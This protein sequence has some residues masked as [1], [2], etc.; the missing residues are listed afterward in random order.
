[1]TSFARWDCC[2]KDIVFIVTGKPKTSYYGFDDMVADRITH[3]ST[4]IRTF[5]SPKLVPGK[6]DKALRLSGRLQK[7]EFE[8][9]DDSCLGNLD[10]C[11]H[12][13][14]LSLWLRFDKLEEGMYYIS[15]GINGITVSYVDRKLRVKASTTTR[16]WELG[17]GR[18]EKGEWHYVEISWDPNT[19][20]KLY[21]DDELQAESSDWKGK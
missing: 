7:A 8:H 19:G 12:G 11:H 15:T 2:N 16:E 5:G 21:V 20:L 1:M 3:P 4:L 13:V 14:L 10:L 18:I 9:T 17:T 6:I